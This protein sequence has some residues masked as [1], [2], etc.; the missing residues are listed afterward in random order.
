M[1]FSKK[2]GNL[3]KISMVVGSIAGAIILGKL[4]LV[5]FNLIGSIVGAVAGFISGWFVVPTIV[6]AIVGAIKELRAFKF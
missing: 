4:G 3:I 5:K 6:G 2:E 1:E